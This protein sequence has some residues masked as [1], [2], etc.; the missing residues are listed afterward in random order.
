MFFNLFSTHNNDD[1]QF[2]FPKI[3]KV[4]D[5]FYRKFE[6]VFYLKVT[7]KKKKKKEKKKEQETK[8]RLRGL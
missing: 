1:K 3:G 4:T 5:R 7:A 6:P 8:Y 2:I